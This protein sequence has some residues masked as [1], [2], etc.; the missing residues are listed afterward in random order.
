MPGRGDG[1]ADEVFVE[2]LRLFDLKAEA[3]DGGEL[4]GWEVE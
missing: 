1:G 4:G 3:R 2:P